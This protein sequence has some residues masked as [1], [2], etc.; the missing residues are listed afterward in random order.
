M[1]AV[2]PGPSRKRKRVGE[3]KEAQTCILH[4]IKL[5][6]PGTFTAFSASKIEPKDKLKQVH[7]IRDRRCQEPFDSPYRM[8]DIM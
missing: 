8:K 1:S 2:E 3:S 5:K 6:D 7:N 4:N